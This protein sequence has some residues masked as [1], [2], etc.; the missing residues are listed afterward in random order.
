ME[1]IVNHLVE[2]PEK[3]ILTLNDFFEHFNEIFNLS[4]EDILGLN[5]DLKREKTS[6]KL[7]TSIKIAESHDAKEI[8]QIFKDVY[9]GT[10]PYKSVED[11]REVCRMIASP[12]HIWFLLRANEKYTVGCFAAELN[13]EE[14]KGRFYGFV[15]RT[16]YQNKIDSFKSF[17]GCVA[18]TWKKYDNRILEWFAEVRTDETTA[19][20]STSLCGLKPIA[21]YPNKDIFVNQIE[22]DFL[23]ITYNINALRKYRTK[24]TPKIIRHVL[25]SYAYCNKK[26]HLGIPKVEN[27]S[28]SLD[29]KSINSLKE[30]V[31]KKMKSR[32]FYDQ[33]VTLFIENSES[34]FEFS[35]NPLIRT[36]EN[37]VYKVSQLEELFVFLEELKKT[38]KY[39]NIRY[40]QCF[41]S[42]YEPSHQI[43][44]EKAGFKPSGY[45]P[46]WKFNKETKYFEDYIVFVYYEGNVNI[47]IKL[48]SETV[49]F[50]KDLKYL[51]VIKKKL[52]KKLSTRV[53]TDSSEILTYLQLGTSIPILPNLSKYIINDLEYFKASSILLLEGGNPAGQVLIY[54]DERET[55]F[56]GYF[57]VL[58][59]NSVK[60]NFLIDEL[61]KYAKEKEYKFIRGPINIPVIIYG[62]GFM[63]EGSL[64]NLFIGKPVNP[65]IYPN[66][67]LKKKFY[68]KSEQVTWLGSR[69]P[70]FDPWK[71]KKYDFSDYEYFYPNDITDFKK[72]KTEFLRIHAENLPS[73]AQITP[74]VSGVFDSYADF[75][76]RYG[77]NFMIFFVKF[78]P[79][80]KIVACGAYLPNPFRKDS[81][82]N[83]DSCVIYTWAVEPK[84]RRKGLGM[85]MYGATS[86]LLWKHKIK[87]GIGPM[88]K[89]N[90]ANMGFAI[91]LGGVIS[92]THL[93]MEFK[94]EKK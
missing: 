53:L 2:I 50:L 66:T 89:S 54:D 20:Y 80:E 77:F 26:Y 40:F 71:L 8:T 18:Y 49:E 69:M 12:N 36:L 23:I 85:L 37:T 73:S 91:K 79:T 19:Q 33:T 3:P 65:P 61:I 92:R 60:I 45:I 13:V 15:I 6:Q 62:W 11:I 86:Q 74:N 1:K 59:H 51:P 68:V 56:F 55:L 24:K 25:D 58:N 67:F 10:Y 63:K 39:L 93:I 88:P 70:R 82:G 17:L 30:K 28:I 7:R 38:M 87:C 64:E 75:V 57:G 83:Y 35:F 27:P 76:F 90:T 21:F 44:F 47:N 32:N 31:F 78:K 34:F 4:Y 52:K 16:E 84:H 72:Y 14:K 41:V 42:A 48:T 29:S 46:S 94:I 81:K 22:S 5:F 9:K 43:L